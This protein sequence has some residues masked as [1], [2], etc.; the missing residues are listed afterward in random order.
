MLTII[1]TSNGYYQMFGCGYEK[2]D[3][4]NLSV[5]RK[6][7]SSLY[8]YQEIVLIASNHESMFIKFANNSW[9]LI[10]S[11]W[12]LETYP[13]EELDYLESYLSEDDVFYLPLPNGKT[14]T[15]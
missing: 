15:Y 2:L 11:Y 4:P 8:D 10:G 9:F 12:Q 6:V 3:N 13:P 1:H 14:S 7:E 5:C